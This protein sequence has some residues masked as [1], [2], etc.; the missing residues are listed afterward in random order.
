MVIAII[1]VGLLVISGYVIVLNWS[2]VIS[3][4]LSNRHSSLVPVI[5][6]VAGA[7]GL[8]LY[9]NP[10]VNRWWPVPLFIDLG[11]FP[12]LFYTAIYFRAMRRKQK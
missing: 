5:G 2:G 10:D 12:L 4:Y 11:A 6:G 7:A 3:N 8:I 1:S 9:P